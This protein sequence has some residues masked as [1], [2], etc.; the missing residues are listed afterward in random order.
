M[1]KSGE[2]T[3]CRAVVIGASSGGQ[4]A[5]ST[6]LA[7]L[8]KK[9]QFPIMIVIHRGREVGDYL[10]R[11]LDKKC[12]CRVKQAD[13]KE[14]AKAGTV[15]VAPPDYHLL[16]EDGGSLA[17]STGL[18]VNYS[19]PSV[20]VLFESAAEVFGAELIGIVLTGANS[21]GS[22]GLK[23]IGELGGVTMVQDPDSAESPSMPR[24]AI[25]AAHPKFVLPIEKI[26]KF[27]LD[28]GATA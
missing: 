23:R 15:Y 1:N 18:P 5:I 3:G 8:P 14:V 2:K 28:F 4:A 11:S 20:D 9:I 17:L 13:D 25:A 6:I 19:R 12:R 10:E 24:S 27:L 7:G 21:D 26:S 22:R 16:V